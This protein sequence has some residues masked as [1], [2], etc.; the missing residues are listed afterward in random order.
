MDIDPMEIYQILRNKQCLQDQRRSELETS[1]Q[2][3]GD[4]AHEPIKRKSLSF[5]RTFKRTK[6]CERTYASLH[7]T[8]L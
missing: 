8:Q 5:K 4:L 2:N 7:H 3:C 6:R 1:G